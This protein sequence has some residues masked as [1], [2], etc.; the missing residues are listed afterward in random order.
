MIIIIIKTY[1]FFNILKVKIVYHQY[2]IYI[3]I[4]I[5]YTFICKYG[6][7][8]LRIYYSIQLTKRDSCLL[9]EGMFTINGKSASTLMVNGFLNGL[10]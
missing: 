9:N 1:I 10:L 6:I 8:N 5:Y 4:Y 3:Y 2:Y 7:I